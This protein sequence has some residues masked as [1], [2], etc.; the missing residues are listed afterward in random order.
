MYPPPILFRWAGG[1]LAHSSSFKRSNGVVAPGS[2]FAW[3]TPTLSCPPGRITRG[4]GADE[5]GWMATVSR[6]ILHSL[7][8]FGLWA[9]L[10]GQCHETLIRG[11]G[12]EKEPR[13]LSVVGLLLLGVSDGASST[14]CSML[15]ARAH[16]PFGHS[17][18]R[19]SVR[20]VRMERAS[21]NRR[22][23]S[24]ISIWLGA[25]RVS[26]CVFLDETRRR[27]FG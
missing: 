3:E 17:A 21:G 9:V 18:V 14:P 6:F 24:A 4:R 7:L 25:R 16:R 27:P 20:A 12:W 1:A 19:P 8:D 15:R 13:P 11:W 10:S 2:F 26:M 5:P 22:S 23:V